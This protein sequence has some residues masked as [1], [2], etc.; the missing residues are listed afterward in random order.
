MDG[1]HDFFYLKTNHQLQNLFKY[2]ETNLCQLTLTVALML[3]GVL[4]SDLTRVEVVLVLVM[5]VVSVVAS[6]GG[7]GVEDLRH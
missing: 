2:Q 6:S 7:L 5:M 3:R 4:H 1:A